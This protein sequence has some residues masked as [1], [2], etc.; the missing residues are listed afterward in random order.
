MTRMVTPAARKRKVSIYREC[1][2]QKAL[3]RWFRLNHPD[4]TELLTIA[5]FGENVGPKTMSRLKAMGLTAGYPDLFLAVPKRVTVEHVI[6]G[7][8][9]P[10]IVKQDIFHGG[11]FLE[12]KTEK[13]LVSEHQFIIHEKLRD[14]NYVVH[15]CRSWDDAKESIED[16]LNIE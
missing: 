1:S 4:L 7:P 2:D 10:K 11:L 13:G 3:V 6:S 8:N 16:Y 12:L 15:V 9:G 5:S 14:K